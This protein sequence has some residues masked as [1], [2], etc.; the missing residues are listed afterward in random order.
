MNR[1]DLSNLKQQIYLCVR[2][3]NAIDEPNKQDE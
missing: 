1:E 3:A 2:V